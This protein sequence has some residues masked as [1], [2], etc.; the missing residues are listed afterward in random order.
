M[1]FFLIFTFILTAIIYTPINATVS[2]YYLRKAESE[3]VFASL[4][5]S[6]EVNMTAPTA[7]IVL[8]VVV[9]VVMAFA[10]NGS[11]AEHRGPS[12]E[13]CGAFAMGVAGFLV[14]IGMFFLLVL[15]GLWFFGRKPAK[16]ELPSILN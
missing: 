15:T 13:A 9:Y 16:I 5:T 8:S 11:C 6:R 10:S 2:Y 14:L 3:V 1:L 7:M 12:A 4:V